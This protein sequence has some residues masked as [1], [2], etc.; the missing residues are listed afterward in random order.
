MR[1]LNDHIHSKGRYVT[2]HSCGHGEAR[3]QCFIDAGFDAWDPQI[4]NDTAR[5]WE[6]FGDQISISV[7]PEPYDPETTSDEEQRRRG[8]EYAERFSVPGKLAQLGFYTG[9]ML[10]PAFTDEVYAQSRKIFLK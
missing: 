1:E 6:D 3:V 7:V 2:L 4:M 10:T 9:P 5:L 8:R